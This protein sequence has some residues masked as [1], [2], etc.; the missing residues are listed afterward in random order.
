[1]SAHIYRTWWLI[2]GLALFAAAPRTLRA[3]PPE[4]DPGVREA[5]KRFQRGVTL[6]AEADYRAALVE[7]RR[8]YLLA[9]STSALYN[10]GETEYQLQD[11][12]NALSSFE[13]YL[14]VAAPN[15]SHRSEVEGNVEVLR[16]RVGYLSI[17]TSPAGADLT[18]DDQPVGKTP[19][20]TPVRVSIGRRKITASLTG[21]VPVTRYVDVAADDHIS[22][23][24]PLLT[25]ANDTGAVPP[26]PEAARS[27]GGAPASP[28]NSGPTLRMAGWITTGALAAGA[29]TFGVIA[30]KKSSDLEDDQRTF[31]TTESML[32]HDSRV[33]TT[34]AVLADSFGAAAL[35][36]GGVTLYFTLT[37]SPERPRDARA[38]RLSVGPTSALF[39]TSF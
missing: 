20:E 21:G 22:L 3:A 26:P 8:A 11:Y 4:G 36:V 15:E 13:R 16:T 19:L 5:A 1:M 28:S 35:I 23:T 38:A 29:I 37:S 9:P 25:S 34:Y 6:Y 27:A 30:K 2:L 24:L 33:L 12:A 39:E 14:A 31:P 32:R 18:V 10:I 17:T 7:F